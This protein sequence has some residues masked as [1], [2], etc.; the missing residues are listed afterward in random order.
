MH[1]EFSYSPFF[2]TRCNHRCKSHDVRFVHSRSRMLNVSRN[3]R[4]NR[5]IYQITIDLHELF[6]NRAW[7]NIRRSR[8][9]SIL[10][11]EDHFSTARREDFLSASRSIDASR[12][13]DESTGF[14]RYEDV[15]SFRASWSWSIDQKRKGIENSSDYEDDLGQFILSKNIESVWYEWETENWEVL[16]WEI[17]TKFISI[18]FKKRIGFSSYI[19]IFLL[20]RDYIWSKLINLKIT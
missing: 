4:S 15:V 17:Y 3:E 9:V 2:T 12:E 8:G 5:L 11:L 7:L 10:R 6:S 13:N 19:F 14:A 18:M 16:F 1:I 20:Y